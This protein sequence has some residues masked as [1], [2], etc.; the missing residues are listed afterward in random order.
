MRFTVDGGRMYASGHPD[1]HTTTD[2]NL[3][4][5]ASA[6]QGTTWQTVSLKGQADFHDLDVAHEASGMVTVY[7]F[8]AGSGLIRVSRDGGATWANGAT[9]A[10]RDF[11]ADPITAGTVFATTA[12][13]MMVSRNFGATFSP[14]TD[15]PSLYLIAAMTG[16]PVGIL[17]GV[18]VGGSIWAKSAGQPWRA[19][20]AAQGQVDAIVYSG[21]AQPVLLLADERGI[22]TSSNLSSTWKTVVTL[23]R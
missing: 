17:I 14:L 21:G 20:G 3:G 10:L 6:D 15:A 9:I 8:D 5:I 11:A 22:V 12:D 4:L 13:G 7:G 2:A 16:S 1:P 19:T 23:S 18:D